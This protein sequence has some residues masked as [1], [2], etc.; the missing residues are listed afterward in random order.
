MK[1]VYKNFGCKVNLCETECMRHMLE[2]CGFETAGRTCDADI[3][4]INSCTVTASGDK[5]TVTYMKQLK[6]RSPHMIIVLTGCYAQAF[7]EEAA[8][9]S[10][11]DIVI[12]TKERA[13]LPLLIKEH[14]RT[15]EKISAVS[16][17]REKDGFELI[18]CDCFKSNTRAFLKI[19]DGCNAFC[20]YCIIPYAR[21]R[22]RSM[23]IDALKSQAEALVR[24]GHREIV[25]CGI[26]LAF[27]GEEWGLSL[28][29]AA[30]ACS[31]AGAERIR[32]GSLEPE[33][34]TE[35]LLLGL[36]GVKGFCPQF[37]LSLQS[38]SDSVLRRMNRRYTAEE[39]ARICTLVRKHF[40]DCA[41]TTD[42]MVG[43]PG[44]TEKEFR[45]TLAFAEKIGFAA[46]HIF[47]YS[48]RQGTKAALMEGQ[49]SENIKINR[50][51]AL[52]KIADKM[53]AVHN[54]KLKNHVISVLF[55]R[56]KGDGFHT[57]HAPDGTLIKIPEKNIKKSLRKS[58]FYVR[59]EE[60]DAAGCYG[61]I[62][63]GSSANQI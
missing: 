5:R 2:G 16:P 35:E 27:Y 18:T 61:T 36:S 10:C 33:R 39:Y 3:A 21:G 48:P 52:Q 54:A 41:I 1:C 40:P 14:I 4:V 45:E 28:C 20:S 38:G 60:S 37:H 31:E 17:H 51:D 25:L 55:E 23:P 49:V 7:P 29:D 44:E 43:F 8:A 42:V 57:G 59:I 6:K 12:G 32:L 47:R 50:S 56:E 53:S 62:V 26:N 19:Q 13:K 11:C 30:L 15:G 9:L 58:L 46:M 34:I 63:S 24:S 22:R